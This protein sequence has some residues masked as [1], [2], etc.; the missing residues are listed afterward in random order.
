MWE[1]ASQWM[2]AAL[3]GVA[4]A[5]AAGTVPDVIKGWLGDQK[6]FL[7]VLCVATAGVFT[8]INLWQQRSRGV[9]IVISLP[10][11]SW[12]EPWSDQW[13]AAASDH[14]RRNH[15]S[16]FAVRREIDAAGPGA[17]AAD[18]AEARKVRKDTLDLAYELVT[19]RLT[20]LSE[21]DPSTPVS[22]YINAALP[23]AFELGAKFKHNVQREL[24][25]IG[26]ALPGDV[27]REAPPEGGNP[28]PR[29]EDAKWFEGTD[30]PVLPQRSERGQSDF[31]SSVRIGSRLK[32]PLTPAEAVRAM[33][34]ARVVDEPP[35]FV[36]DAE[37]RAVALVVHLSDNPLM[38]SQALR[39]AG[40]GCADTDGRWDRCRAALVVDGGPANIPESVA[41]F[42][43]VVRH[44]Y[45]AWHGWVAARPQ[46]TGLS[47]RIFI[48]APVSVAFALGWLFGHT[49]KAVPHPYETDKPGEPCSS[50]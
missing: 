49:V 39:A 30:T 13:M 16:R 10:R 36:G 40:E 50:S 1:G 32:D 20:E 25:G 29:Q 17:D 22:L 28:P 45:A 33:K 21:S 47:P 27:R 37:G 38:V 31:F 43:L 14:A 15:D 23:D 11:K 3:A 5:V 4:A 41:D 19:I 6:W 8:G 44:V 42:E 9:G 2:V 34:L 24:R 26:S 46:Y 7:T 48:A 35:G 18:R 12:R